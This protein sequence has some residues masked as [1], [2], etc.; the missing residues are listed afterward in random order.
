MDT[1][2]AAISTITAATATDTDTLGIQLVQGALYL[3]SLPLYYLVFFNYRQ[4]FLPEIY[5]KITAPS[6]GPGFRRERKKCLW[7]KQTALGCLL[8]SLFAQLVVQL[9]M[10]PVANLKP[11][12]PLLTTSSPVAHTSPV[13]FTM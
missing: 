2:P 4:R 3:W 6:I 12:F 7:C 8:E 13:K 5:E 1:V 11:R 10:E 9:S